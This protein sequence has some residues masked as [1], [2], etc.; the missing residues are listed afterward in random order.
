MSDSEPDL[1][2]FLQSKDFAGDAEAT[3]EAEDDVE[4]EIETVDSFQENGN[5]TSDVEATFGYSFDD[6]ALGEALSSLSEKALDNAP[7]GIVRVD[8]EGIVQFYNQYESQLAGVAPEDAVG[9][10]FFTELAPCSSNR[11]FHGRFKKGM[12]KGALDER[13]S[14]TFTYKMSPTLVQVRM[15]RDE[16]NHNWIMIRKQS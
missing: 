1:Y 8:D 5:G 7:F 6:E 3:S 13:F 9:R 16:Q 11:L 12:R 2:S 14:Y 4:A 10:N 15:Y